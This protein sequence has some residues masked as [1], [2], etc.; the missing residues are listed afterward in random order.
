MGL[1]ALKVKTLFDNRDA[2]KINLKDMS[3][4]L[5]IVSDQSQLLLSFLH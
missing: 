5:N 4:F 3:G 1:K 2:K